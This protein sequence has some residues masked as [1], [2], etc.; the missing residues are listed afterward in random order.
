MAGDA[1]YHVWNSLSAS[2]IHDIPTGYDVV[3]LRELVSLRVRDCIRMLQLSNIPDFKE[4]R[5]QELIDCIRRKTDTI[6]THISP[7]WKRRLKTSTAM[8]KTEKGE[9]HYI[10]VPT[11]AFRLPTH[12]FNDI[13]GT[14][15]Y[16]C[17]DYSDVSDGGA[18]VIWD[19]E[20]DV[21][22]RV[23]WEVYQRAQ[24]GNKT[25]SELDSHPVVQ[26]ILPDASLRQQYLTCLWVFD[27]LGFYDVGSQSLWSPRE[28]NRWYLRWFDLWLKADAFYP[29]NCTTTQHSILLR[30]KYPF[31]S[32]WS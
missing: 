29:P 26:A 19:I 11:H 9:M 6:M 25:L 27:I 24:G 4:I 30:S 31:N 18:R 2:W 21:Y 12:I 7:L 5:H 1:Q 23:S 3:S 13:G 28:I 14:Y 10:D 15:S 32:A 20:G 17:I 16:K 8:Y 22:G